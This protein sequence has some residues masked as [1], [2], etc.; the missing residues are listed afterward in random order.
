M[1]PV[2]R[3]GDNCTGH[4][5]CPPRPSIEGE[6]TVTVSGREMMRVGHGYDLHGCPAHAPHGAVLADGA[7]HA[8]LTGKPIGRID[9]PVSCGSKVMEG[10]PTVTI[11]DAGGEEWGR[12][13]TF[14]LLKN[15]KDRLILCLPEIAS[16]EYDRA[17]ERDKLGWMSFYEAL[18]K[19]LR[20]PPYA[21]SDDKFDNGGQA[22]LLVQW[23]WLMRYARFRRTV[24]DILDTQYL[25]GPLGRKLLQEILEG[26]GA[27]AGSGQAFDHINLPWDKLRSHAFQSLPM[28]A[29]RIGW[30][31]LPDAK[32]DGLAV[33]IGNLV[34]LAVAKGFTKES[35]SGGHQICVEAVG[36]FI[37]D[38]FEF[39]GDQWLGNWE[40][41]SDYQG[42]ASADAVREALSD[43]ADKE[44][45]LPSRL[46]NR[47]FRHFRE[48]S[49]YG[50]DFRIMNT[51]EPFSIWE[52]Y[53]FERFCYD[54]TP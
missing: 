40:C 11:G 14:S 43:L 8:S 42:F 35:V 22:P 18:S 1:P 4:D 47:A 51:P 25:F 26:E 20:K 17:D 52:L 54:A 32:P 36:L 3:K 10:E 16:A 53:L 5:A 15:P 44:L 13:F 38:G 21:M 12:E 30:G 46:D 27:F 19:W 28:E 48:R 33:V 6:P 37:H 50:C 2:T 24:D 45:G 39:G 7:P 29:G 31:T 49:G 23:D 9:D 34:L 41:S